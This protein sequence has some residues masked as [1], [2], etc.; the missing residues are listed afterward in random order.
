MKVPFCIYADFECIIK[1]NN[2][3]KTIDD[4]KS[5]V[6]KDSEHIPCGYTY[7]IISEFQ[8]E[9]DVK[10]YRGEDCIDHFIK[11][12][13]NDKHGILNYIK[14]QDSKFGNIKNM[15]ITEEQ[16]IQ[17][18]EASHCHIC[19]KAFEVGDKRHRDHCHIT[20]KYRGPAHESCNMH[21]NYGKIIKSNI[22]GEKDKFFIDIP[23]TF[24]N[25]KGYDSHLIIS[26]L[27]NNNLNNNSLNIIP[28]NKEKYL[29]FSIHCLKFI[30]SFNFLSSSLENLVSNLN[31]CSGCG[32]TLIDDND[33]MENNSNPKDDV[34]DCTK[35]RYKKLGCYWCN[36]CK[37]WMKQDIKKLKKTFKHTYNKFNYLDDDKFKLLLRKGVYPYEY[38]DS[39][40][41]FKE[42]T[43]PSKAAF[44]NRLK[45]EA[46]SDDDYKHAKNIWSKFGIKNLGEYHDLYLL[47]DVL[48]LADVF[49]YFRNESITSFKLDPLYYISLPSYAWDCMLKTT[50]VRIEIF[51]DKQFDMYL[52]NEKCKRGGISMMINRYAKANNPYM[53]NFNPNE[54]VKYL[55]YLDANNLYGW[56]MIQKL[57]L[58]GFRW[59]DDLS[60]FTE[61]YCKNI[62]VE[63]DSGYMLE[64]DLEYPTELHDTHN[65]YPVA[66]ESMIVSDNMLSPY[67]KSEKEALKVSSTKIEKLVP[68]LNNKDRYVVHFRNLQLYLKLGL[69]LTK[70]HKVL[71]FNQSKWLEHYID[72]NTNKRKVAKNEFEKDFY[73]LMNN[74]VFGNTMENVRN[75]ID[76]QLISGEDQ[77][78]KGIYSKRVNSFRFKN[79]NF[80]NDELVGVELYKHKVKL[81]KPIIVGC[82]ILEI[83]KC[84]MY[85]FHYNVMIKKY[86]HEN[87]KL[88][89]TDTDSLVYEIT[90]EDFYK[91]I[92]ND[93]K[94]RD[95]FDLSNYDEKHF[96]HDN[97]NKKVE[98][99][100]KD[101][102]AG[103]IMT[104]FVGL[105]S[106]MY[107]FTVDENKPKLSKIV[108][109][110]INKA[111]KKKIKHDDYLDCYHNNVII[112]SKM[113]SLRSYN[114]KMYS[115]VSN[116]I[117]LSPYEDK[118]YYIDGT[119]SLRY[120]HYKIKEIENKD[121]IINE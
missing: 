67:S 44:Y 86:G 110:G 2:D 58:G 35:T 62:D 51:N 40:D 74:A 13:T 10:C 57:P 114:H 87:V 117:G 108:A 11:N 65:D 99:K 55:M 19:E 68:N 42:T 24:H 50:G 84:C 45:D 100:F 25:L 36:D 73:K 8:S 94:L 9:P 26:R 116:K 28:L 34:H 1:K 90:T 91:D 80:I 6:I 121:V 66:V 71:Q 63:G 3:N 111:A 22:E 109:K 32:N 49:E 97:T 96:L 54:A 104:E 120:G 118:S 93:K 103:K 27:N 20:G 43:L 119:K 88:L 72:T 33:K 76:Y 12:I 60:I 81:D 38:M 78:L 16:E 46:I 101:E 17:C 77:E 83:S 14:E 61:D 64:V 7:T 92:K 70:V 48:L 18:K 113:Y 47:T 31:T 30:D 69:K 75:R 41:R 85:D 29:T 23:A 102:N 105:K 106:K 89:M 82:S 52:F 37:K 56:A 4:D 53:K 15:I 39:F 98:G 59:V 21:Y 5:Y 112:M 107:S 95:N 79:V 115:I